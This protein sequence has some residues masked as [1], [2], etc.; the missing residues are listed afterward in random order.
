MYLCSLFCQLSASYE[1]SGPLLA[2]RAF[3]SAHALDLVGALMHDVLSHQY[4]HHPHY[5]PA[6]DHLSCCRLH[7]L[8]HGIGEVVVPLHSPL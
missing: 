8:C 1:T 7:A 2:A 3:V 6:T 4:H 5:F